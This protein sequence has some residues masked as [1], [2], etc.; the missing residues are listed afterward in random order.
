MIEVVPLLSCD[1]CEFDCEIKEELE[2]HHALN[3][4]DVKNNNKT[5][6]V[7]LVPYFKMNNCYLCEFETKDPKEMKTHCEEKHGDYTDDV[8]SIMS[9]HIMNHTGW[10]IFA[11][12][13]C[14]FET[15]RELMLKNNQARKRA[16]SGS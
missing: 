15:T 7:S 12:Y 13:P 4:H 5:F 9:E 1:Q 8:A 14:E 3:I 2:K 16:V 6:N 11:C 10:N